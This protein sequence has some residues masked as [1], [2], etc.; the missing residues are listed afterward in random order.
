[1]IGLERLKPLFHQACKPIIPTPPSKI[2]CLLTLKTIITYYLKD[3]DTIVER[4]NLDDIK[5]A[6][7]RK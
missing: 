4:K 6:P 1:M 3:L 2:L 7:F 5:E